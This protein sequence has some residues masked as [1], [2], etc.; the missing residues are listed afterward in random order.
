MQTLLG[1][2]YGRKKIGLSI[3]YSSIA[4]PLLVIKNNG[5]EK[6]VD[7]I[8]KI[9]KRENVM[10]V[11][12]GISERESEKEARD[13][14][15]ILGDKTGVVI[16]FQ[17][18]TLSTKEAQARSIE[19]GLKRKKRKEMEDAYAATLILQDYLDNS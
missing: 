14:G 3:A 16:I 9:T 5:I 13:F 6:T 19:A 8:N 4:E 7:E 1:V 17:D 11:V 10:E 15:K 2:D 18:E 12:V